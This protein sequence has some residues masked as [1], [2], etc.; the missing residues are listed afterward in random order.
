[1]SASTGS[2][3]DLY[4][5]QLDQD[6]RVAGPE[7]EGGDYLELPSNRLR[8]MT[9]SIQSAFFTVIST[10]TNEILLGVSR[11]T[12]SVIDLTSESI[13]RLNIALSALQ[14]ENCDQASRV[15][16]QI[17]LDVLRRCILAFLLLWSG[18][19]CLMLTNHSLAAKVIYRGQFFIF[20]LSAILIVLPIVFGTLLG[21]WING[22]LMR[23]NRSERS[24]FSAVGWIKKMQLSSLGRQLTHPMPPISKIEEAAREQHGDI[25]IS[26]PE[27]RKCL[28]TAL[29]SLD[30]DIL[31][32]LRDYGSSGADIDNISVHYS[33]NTIASSGELLMLSTALFQNR[34][35]ISYKCIL[36]QI[37]SSDIYC[38]KCQW[39]TPIGEILLPLFCFLKLP[40]FLISINMAL[41]QFQ[42]KLNLL[43][44]DVK[45]L[46]V[47]VD[48]K[49]EETG[50]SGSI[51]YRN[52]ES[53]HAVIQSKFIA[54]R[55]NL[56]RYRLE[57]EGDL[58]KLWLCEQELST[59]STTR[60]LFRNG[61]SP[62][63]SSLSLPSPLHFSPSV[64]VSE[65]AE[66][67]Y[68]T[69]N[70]NQALIKLNKTLE[71]ME[72][73]LIDANS[74]GR[75]SLPHN[76][77]VDLQ[78]LIVLISSAERPVNSMNEKMRNRKVPERDDKSKISTLENFRDNR[79]IVITDESNMIKTIF[80]DNNSRKSDDLN[81]SS[82]NDNDNI[83]NGE[84][85]NNSS[86]R[87]RRIVDVYSATVAAQSLSNES[88]KC[89]KK[90]SKNGNNDEIQNARLLLG[91]LQNH[92]DMLDLNNKI[93]ERMQG[94]SDDNNDDNDDNSYKNR[95]NNDN[96]DDNNNSN[97]NDINDN[98]DNNNDDTNYN[99]NSDNNTNN[100]DN[101]C[102]SRNFNNY[103]NNDTHSKND[104]ISDEK[105]NIKSENDMHGEKI[106]ICGQLKKIDNT[107]MRNFDLFANPSLD[108]NPCEN[109]HRKS[110]TS[111]LLGV[112]NN[113]KN[114]EN[115][116]YLSEEHYGSDSDNDHHSDS[117][118]DINHEGDIG[119]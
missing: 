37:I 25:I 36:S 59:I 53:H 44:S 58:N 87:N 17:L 118:D 46:N 29:K 112:L 19:S 68:M 16:S 50:I 65:N 42:R 52:D 101:N 33:E 56:L 109:F 51:A 70:R 67:Q 111:E 15:H 103:R 114:D 69:E 48:I 11:D 97:D 92:I 54:I 55:Q 75:S 45:N 23:V 113:V 49:G 95:S 89:Y 74:N 64:A 8:A 82:I 79:L 13:V 85:S 43:C 83:D 104:E 2:Q 7:K 96:N 57:V 60:I 77:G 12:K 86:N 102:S 116:F 63:P 3:L 4:L 94:N 62:L 21:Q 14:D 5:A 9:N 80:E 41:D 106:N 18:L 98:N 88:T 6:Q 24:T 90:D 91:E 28:K 78:A 93:I 76:L 99:D 26:C 66:T 40:I 39:E 61:L 108:E 84:A 110:L 38:I 107:Q 10:T 73:L 47:S 32:A 115:V 119:Q 30:V 27:M 72:G 71:Y 31:A 81:V 35:I 34:M 105:S 100:N 22:T 117:G 1:M 20:S